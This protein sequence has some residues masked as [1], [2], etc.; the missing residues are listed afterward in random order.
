MEQF[1]SLEPNQKRLPIIIDTK[2]RYY[3][4]HLYREFLQI[5]IEL[6]DKCGIEFDL[7]YDPKGWLAMIENID[8]INSKIL[9]IHQG[10][11][12]GNVSMIKR[13]KREFNEDFR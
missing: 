6:K 10:G 5:W 13:Y 2:K 3:F 1:L 11:L 8:K 7:L 4:G 9:Y 12:L